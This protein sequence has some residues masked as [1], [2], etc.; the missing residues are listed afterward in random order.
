MMQGLKRISTA[1]Q[2]LTIMSAQSASTYANQVIALVIPWLILTRTGNAASA[3]TIAFA[4]GIASLAGTLVG[5]LVTDR[6]G[7]RRVSILADGLSMIT[8]LALA[9]ALWTG[10]FSLWLVAI[11]QIL[12]VFFDGPGNIA[13]SST[14]PAAAGEENV[15]ITRAMG[16]TQT[17]QGIATFVGPITAG[18]LI[19]A[20]GEANTLLVTTVLFG[21]SILLATRLRK[22]VITHE[23]PM[24]VRQTY[25]D[26]REAVQ[27]LVHEPFLG[28]MQLVG[29]LMGAVIVPISALIIP[30]WFVFAQQSSRALG[31]FLAA[32]AVGGTI[33]G[34]VFAAVAQK[35]PQR[36]WLVGATSLYAVALLGLFFTRPGSVAAIVVGFFAGSMMSVMFAVPFS[37]FYSRTPQ[38]LLGRVGSLGAAHGS[39]MGALASLGF[40][41]LLHNL[42]APAALLVSAIGMAAVALL[43]GTAPFMRHLDTPVAVAESTSAS[44]SESPLPLAA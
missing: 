33:G 1:R 20:F 16:L 38:H 41:Y 42:S 28:K 32:G 9:V 18:L 17:L 24:S 22:R 30:A 13:K 29:P 3:G 37:A 8:A 12:G 14:V 34:L 2:L 10:A 4:M 15:P 27:F 44:A 35:L 7:G 19:A 23:Q 5:G 6:I 36:T 40:G 11:T 25:R 21:L 31:V 26:M 43:L 39:L